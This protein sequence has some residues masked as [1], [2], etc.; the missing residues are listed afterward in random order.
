MSKSKVVSAFPAS[1]KST[2]YR[3]CSQYSKENMWRKRNNG[4]QV[5]N[6]VGFP[7]GEKIIDSDSSQLVGLKMRMGIILM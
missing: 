7:C 2:Y 4:E 3:E 1:G 5:F 6:N